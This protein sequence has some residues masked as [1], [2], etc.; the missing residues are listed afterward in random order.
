MRDSKSKVAASANSDGSCQE[1][2]IESIN[3]ASSITGAGT[4]EGDSASDR[5]P[6]SKVLSNLSILGMLGVSCYSLLIMS[7]PVARALPFLSYAS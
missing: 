6:L 4:E 3:A 5:P 7:V 1:D 2:N